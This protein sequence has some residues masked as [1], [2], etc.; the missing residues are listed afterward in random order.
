MDKAV[1]SQLISTTGPLGILAVIVWWELA[2][3]G[4]TLVHMQEDLA[5]CVAGLTSTSP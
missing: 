4:S 1:I 2:Q 3:Q 5:V